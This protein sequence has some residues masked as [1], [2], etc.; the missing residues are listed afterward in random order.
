MATIVLSGERPTRQR[1]GLKIQTLSED[2]VGLVVAAAGSE[3]RL[4]H[5]VVI[6]EHPGQVGPG[7][8]R[9]DPAALDL[10][11][12]KHL[13]APPTVAGDHPEEEKAKPANAAQAPHD[14]PYRH[15]REPP[16]QADQNLV[17]VGHREY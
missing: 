10:A 6:L 2:P 8:A 17:D 7:N 16:V 12:E 11:N 14:P 9:L 4:D 1:R 5:R 15:G 13:H 3:D